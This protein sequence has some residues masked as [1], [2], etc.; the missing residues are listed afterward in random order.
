MCNTRSQLYIH[1]VYMIYAFG[2]SVFAI[3][4]CDTIHFSML[5]LFRIARWG[6]E[7]VPKTWCPGCL[8]SDMG[9]EGPW[10]LVG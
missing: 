9:T 7:N 6:T 2:F 8:V 1:K 4:F 3:E 5:Q 10:R